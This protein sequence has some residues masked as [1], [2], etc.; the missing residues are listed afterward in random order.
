MR[1]IAGRAGGRRLHAPPEGTRPTTDRVREALFSSLDAHVRA[2]QG[3]WDRVRVLDLFAGSGAVGLEALSRGAAAATLV[4]RDRRC[5]EVLRR[6]V[7]AVDP[8][9]HV[10]AADALAWVPDG[11][12]YNIAYVDPPYALADETVRDLLAM[13][14]KAGT[15]AE[16]ALV[17]VERSRRSGE[18]W[19]VSGGIVPVRKREYG[20]TSL[21][22]GLVSPE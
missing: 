6:N 15:F 13:L 2:G 12:P 22:Y 3:G 21:W 5:L 10:V 20:D 9:A 11:D 17:V 14:V 4:E 8:A 19:P 16:G 1:I 18:P 7:A